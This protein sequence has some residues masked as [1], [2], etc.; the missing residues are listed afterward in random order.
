MRTLRQTV[1]DDA[2]RDRNR[3]EKQPTTASE[4]EVR[5]GK[6][7]SE[8]PVSAADWFKLWANDA[9]LLQRNVIAFNLVAISNLLNLPST[10]TFTLHLHSSPYFGYAGLEARVVLFSPDLKFFS[11]HLLGISDPHTDL[12]NLVLLLQT[13][14]P[15]VHRKLM[16][17]QIHLT[18]TEHGNMTGASASRVL[19]ALYKLAPRKPLF[20]TPDVQQSLPQP[21]LLPRQLAALTSD[22]MKQ[23]VDQYL[24]R[25][26]LSW[27]PQQIQQVLDD[28]A[29]LSQSKQFENAPQSTSDVSFEQSWAF[30]ET[31]FRQLRLF[32]GGI[33]TAS[34][35]KDP[36]SERVSITALEITSQNATQI[37]VV[38]EIILQA[39][40]FT[41]LRP[42]I[43]PKSCKDMSD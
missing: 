27:S 8:K 6:A 36:H 34:A 15:H 39:R 1:T 30:A 25:L 43:L 38:A 32:I 23:L 14:C 29:A 2:P 21:P 33:A 22:Q 16:G 19:A 11:F 20:F 13:L 4:D 12:P 31:Q 35:Y 5:P 10:W 37:T 28:H 9:A 26:Q 24:P 18:P 40:Q 42:F 41:Q 7:V 3:Q 17:V